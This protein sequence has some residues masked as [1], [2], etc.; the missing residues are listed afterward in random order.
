[1]CW[2]LCFWLRVPLVWRWAAMIGKVII[3]LCGAS[4]WVTSWARSSKADCVNHCAA[5]EP[6]LHGHVKTRLCLTPLTPVQGEE[7]IHFITPLKPLKYGSLLSEDEYGEIRVQGWVTGSTRGETCC[8]LDKKDWQ[9]K[10][11][12]EGSS[13]PQER[14]CSVALTRKDL[15]F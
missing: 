14:L 2:V 11:L 13:L 12:S 9:P 3:G 8:S 10:L 5:T 15:T 6:G 7:L 1:M 4:E